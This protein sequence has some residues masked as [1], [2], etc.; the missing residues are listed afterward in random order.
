MTLFGFGSHEDLLLADIHDLYANP[1]DR[2]DFKSRMAAYGFVRDLDLSMR[3][4]QHAHPADTIVRLVSRYGVEPTLL[5]LEI[6]ESVLMA[7]PRHVIDVLR[8]L[9]ATG[10]N[11]AIDDFG[12]GYSSLACLANLPVDT[13]KIDRSFVS[14]LLAG[15]RRAAIVQSTVDLAHVLALRVVAEG[16]ED[17]ATWHAL[18]E[19]GC[20]AAQGYYIAR[21]LPAGDI[22]DWF[23]E[24]RAAA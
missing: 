9:R 10:V 12:T 4:L 19:H 8:R 15:K 18:A 6:T 1:A 2:D 7:D 5:E 22:E 24:S 11:V 17:E 3:D 21:P 14:G 23:V 16:V 20:D 13:L